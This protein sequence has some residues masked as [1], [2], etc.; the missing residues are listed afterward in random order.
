M[1]TNLIDSVPQN[2]SGRKDAFQDDEKFKAL[3]QNQVRR[4]FCGDVFGDLVA[5][6]YQVDVG[7]KL[8]A[9]AEDGW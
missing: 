3:T 7:E 5:E 2:R 8:F 9:G 1:S 4:F 6:I